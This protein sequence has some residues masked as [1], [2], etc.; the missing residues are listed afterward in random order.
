MPTEIS[1]ITF[2]SL[3]KEYLFVFYSCFKIDEIIVCVKFL[4]KLT[5][6][7]EEYICFWNKSYEYNCAKF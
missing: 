4:K 2:V 3:F 1:Y 7:V 5:I 6:Y